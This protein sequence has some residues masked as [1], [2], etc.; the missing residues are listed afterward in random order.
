MDLGNAVFTEFNMNEDVAA[1][2]AENIELFDCDMGL[3]HSHHNMSTSPSGTDLN[4][5]REEGNERNCF[6][7]L[8]VNNA[9][10]YYAAITRK[11]HIKSEVVVKNLGTSYEFFGEGSKELLNNNIEGTKIIDKEIIEYY[12]LEVERHEVVNNLA[13]LDT[14]FEEIISKKQT[15][16]SSFGNYIGWNKEDIGKLFGKTDTKQLDMFGDSYKRDYS[17]DLYGKDK[18]KDI[19]CAL[20]WEPDPKKIH[21]AVINILSCSLIVNPDKFDLKQWVKKHMVNVYT[22]TFG[23]ECFEDC[24]HNACG[25]FTGWKD[26]IIQFVMDNYNVDGVPDEVLEEYELFQS[27]IAEAIIEE[28]SEF[29]NEN[30]FIQAYCA[31]LD[32]YITM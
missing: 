31:S 7:S 24:K 15:E 11:V 30:I 5:L 27:K 19:N 1:Y 9:G 2:M 17:T 4:T 26:F 8:I 32:D 22:K 28:L 18:K 10:V 14:R 21:K 12:D 3:V 25:A 13:Y 23:S 29:A 20:D 6:V 16:N